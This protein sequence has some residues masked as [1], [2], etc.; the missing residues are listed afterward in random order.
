MIAEL[1]Q[2]RKERGL[3]L[4]ETDEIDITK[5]SVEDKQDWN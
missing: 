5:K 4:E 3:D 1:R 2:S